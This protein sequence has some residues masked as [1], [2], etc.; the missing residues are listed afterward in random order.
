[1]DPKRIVVKGGSWF[2]PAV[3]ARSAARLPRLRDELDVNLGF[4]L[5]RELD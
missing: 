5:L 3:M 2:D 1:G 4:R